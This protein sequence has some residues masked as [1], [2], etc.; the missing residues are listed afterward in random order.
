MHASVVL[1]GSSVGTTWRSM[2]SKCATRA[3][4]QLSE[5]ELIIG[6]SLNNIKPTLRYGDKYATCL[7]GAG[8]VNVA[9]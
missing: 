5:E 7:V 2:G 8:I 4:Q 1:L 6:G 3:K 9:V